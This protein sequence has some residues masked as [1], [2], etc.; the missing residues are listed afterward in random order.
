MQ[1]EEITL[2]T[3]DKNFT[4]YTVRPS[5]EIKGGLIVI[6]EVWGLTAHIKAVARRYASDG[7]YVLAP[8]L[9]SQTGI[10]ELVGDLQ[11]DLFDP[12]KRAAAQPKIRKLMAPIQSPEFARDTV[13][14]LSECFNFLF[15]KGETAQKVAVTGFCFGGTYSFSLAMAEPKL[16]AAVV[17]YGHCN[18]PVEELKKID[19][20]V[21]AFYGEKDEGLI[22]SLDELKNNMLDAGVD[23]TA[24]VYPNC[25]HA[26]FNDTNPYAYNK[27]AASDS[28]V[29]SLEFLKSNIG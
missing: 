20:P 13:V 14:K 9:L 19:C 4:A 1:E 6:H 29:R 10:V 25:G 28:W 26:F 12:E 7:Y 8:D 23:F 27:D 18:A 17:Y 21:L 24:K 5:A 3:K 11:K 22:G 2:T 16:K 15:S